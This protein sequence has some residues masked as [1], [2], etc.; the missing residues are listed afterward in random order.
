LAKQFSQLVHNEIESMEELIHTQA[1]GYNPDLRN[2]LELLLSAGGKR[3]RPTVTFLTGKMLGAN[4]ERLIILAA[5]V[6]MLHTAT[7]VHDDLIDGSLLRRGSP[8]LNAQWSPG[9]TVLTGDFIFS[10]SAKLA[11]ETNSV[12]LM[13]VFAQTL[14]IIVNGE[15]AQLFDRH[16]QTGRED[17]FQRIYAKTASLFETSTHTA[18]LL[19]PASEQTIAQM[20]LYGYNIGM[21]FQIIDDIL[22]FTGEQTKLGKP[23]G[24]D[25]R[26][27]I[28]TL[29]VICFNE[30]HPE[31][32]ATKTLLVD[33]YLEPELVQP[34]IEAILK[35]DA[36][37]LAYHEAQG[38]TQKAVQNLENLPDSPERSALAELAAYIVE[39]NS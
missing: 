32:N 17:Y 18:A 9:A 28:I 20:S 10:R 21:A 4:V 38:F 8:T 36:I 6:E 24:S 39:R 5:A 35:S 22:D 33:R 14:T 23:I 15:M 13:K 19:S 31:D 1:D 34:L 27:G 3:I 37:Q 16:D 29:P 12:E 30:L 26:Q 25:L 11:A 7:L 2:A